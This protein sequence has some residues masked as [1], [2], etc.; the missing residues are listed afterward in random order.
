MI[1]R[2]EGDT[3]VFKKR[4]LLLKWS[5]LTVNPLSPLDLSLKSSPGRTDNYQCGQLF[6][7]QLTNIHLNIKILRQE[8]VWLNLGFREILSTV[9]VSVFK[10]KWLMGFRINYGRVY[11]MPQSGNVP[12][13]QLVMVTWWRAEYL[14]KFWEVLSSSFW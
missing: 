13:L 2:R 8:D 1:W 14:L 5:V 7:L 10:T 4:N 6:D 3:V 12:I 9:L 11:W